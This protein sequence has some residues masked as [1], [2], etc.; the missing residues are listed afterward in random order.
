MKIAQIIALSAA[1]VIASVSFAATTTQP[2]VPA[3]K[4]TTAV[5]TTP[6]TTVATKA[7]TTTIKSV[8][9]ATKTVPT[10]KTTVVT[11]KVTTSGFKCK[12]GSISKAKST[13]G[14]CSGHGGIAK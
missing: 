11:K 5:K 8:S 4:T 12:D 14:A 13:R 9:K 6:A 3:S 2:T 7:Q 10:S 1:T